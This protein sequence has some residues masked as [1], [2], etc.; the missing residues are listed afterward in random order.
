MEPDD[1]KAKLHAWRTDV[2]IPR[3]FQAEVWQRIAAR[4]EARQHSSW[5]RFRE[6]VLTQLARPQYATA[7]IAVSVSA[8][9]ALAHLQAKG[10]NAKHWQEL[11]TRYVNSITPLPAPSA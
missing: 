6:A 11:E 1:L 4:E 8:A 2:E 9:L 10:T 5:N 3:R 7:L